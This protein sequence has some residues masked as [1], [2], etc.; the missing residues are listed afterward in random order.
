MV[1]SADALRGLLHRSEKDAYVALRTSPA[2]HGDV[3]L[4]E[5][6]SEILETSNESTTELNLTL[7][8][9]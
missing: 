5:M 1:L 3:I 6:H 9:L 2:F 8:F 7:P 4:Y